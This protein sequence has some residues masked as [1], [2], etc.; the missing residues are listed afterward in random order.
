[1]NN[2][3]KL[4]VIVAASTTIVSTPVF[5]DPMVAVGPKIGT[6][7]FGIEA[8]TPIN[9][10]LFARLGVNYFKY[11]KNLSKSS[12]NYK[13]NLTLLS[14]P[15]MVDYHPFDNSGFRLSAGIAYNGNKIDVKASPSAPVTVRGISYTPAQ[16]GNISGKAKLGNALG[17]L[18]TL[19]YD[20]SFLGQNPL[21]FAFEAGIMYA[22]TPKAS[23]KATGV[24]GTQTQF[25]SDIKRDVNS[26][27][28][29]L[30][31]FPVLSIGLKYSF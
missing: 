7:G 11:K 18:L 16:I 28:K 5:A 12:I 21:S 23:I 13:G 31:I 2:F 4:A 30:K 3:T 9:E 1:M 22:G 8:R 10:N 6:Q 26:A 14:V 20:S 17:G 15:L 29:Y 24:A 25:I 19:G 27:L